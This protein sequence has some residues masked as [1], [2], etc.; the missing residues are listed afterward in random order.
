MVF[1]AAEAG[2]V[3]SGSSNLLLPPVYEIFW[4]AIVFLGL[5]IVLGLALKKIYAKIDERN[6]EI[7][8]GLDA[9]AQS[10]EQAA[11]AERER[12]DLLRDA[13]EQAREVREKASQD[14]QRIVAQAKTEAQSEAARITDN[15]T[16]QIAAERAA[17]ELTL[18]RDV[19]EL[20]T[21]L[22]EKIIGEKLKDDEVSSRVIDRFMD[23]LESSMET[24]G[25][26]AQ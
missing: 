2:E 25:A 9:A 17:A 11:L 18:R 24:E 22:A 15:A 3:S 12:K 16:K 20:A 13:N 7:E 1:L 8:A 26:N 14:A 4:S 19:G 10:Q 23:Q 21:E 6:E 5:W